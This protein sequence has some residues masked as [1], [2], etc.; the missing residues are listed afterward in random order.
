VGDAAAAGQEVEV[1]RRAVGVIGRIAGCFLALRLEVD[2]E[3]RLDAKRLEAPWPDPMRDLARVRSVV[4]DLDGTRCRLRTDCLGHA[5][6]A[7]QPAGVALPT[8]VAALGPAPAPDAPA[9]ETAI[10]PSV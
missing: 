9:T 2:L 10:G 4:L 5:A 6:K 7:F 3:R 8:A 1:G